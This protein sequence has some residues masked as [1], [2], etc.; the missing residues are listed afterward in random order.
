MSSRSDYLQE[1][2][3]GIEELLKPPI[4]YPKLEKILAIDGDSIAWIA[5]YTGKDESGN[6][7]P[8]YTPE[9][10]VI[11]EGIADEIFMKIVNVC[12]EFFEITNT[13]LCLKGFNNPRHKWHPVYKQGRPPALPIINHINNYLFK[14]Y[15]GLRPE[16][17]ETDDLIAD[18]AI[19]GG[20]KVVIAGFD[21]DLKQLGNHWFLSYKAWTWDFVTEERGKYLFHCQWICGDASD[22]VSL[23]PKVGIKFAEKV[24]KEGMN[25][26]ELMEGVYSGYLK[27]WKDPIIAQ[28][29]MILAYRLLKLHPLE[30][31]K[32]LEITD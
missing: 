8:D 24:I 7:K 15:S 30:D 14:K 9:E 1:K 17:G 26:W 6:K 2:D 21:K 11:A 5:S 10:Y 4:K 32:S 28:E 22:G 29:N 20:E 31:L 3:N 19:K 27:A 25:D 13:Y 23:S 12:E 18:I 16:I